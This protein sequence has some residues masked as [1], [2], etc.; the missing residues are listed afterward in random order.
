[1][2]KKIILLVLLFAF[3][4]DE[5]S[6]SS[7][8]PNIPNYSFSLEINL[9]LPSNSSLQFASNHI[10]NLSVGAR[11][12]VV[13]NT[14]SGYVAFDLA[15]PNQ[16]FEECTAP[17]T[18]NGIEASCD[19]DEST[20]SLFSGQGNEDLEYALKQYNVEVSGNIITVYN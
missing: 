4:C 20:Y 1:M 5:D 16:S 15:C 10:T 18:I 13:F 11:G 2:Y 3:S 9:N 7:N 12:I 14:G 6:T 19:C 17:M 8:N